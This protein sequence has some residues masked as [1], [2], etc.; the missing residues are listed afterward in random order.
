MRF[1]LLCS[2]KKSLDII[3]MGTPDFAVA[4]LDKIHKSGHKVRAVITSVDKPAGRGK[5][6]RQSA[7]KKYALEQDILILQP[8]NLKDEEFNAALKSLDADL[9]VVVAFR[10]LPKV[11]WDMPKM[12]TINL[13]GS[14]LPDY[15][16][17]APINWAVINGDNKTGVSTFF[18]NE[19]I[20]T[21]ELLL[22]R[23]INISKNDTAGSVHDAMMHIGAECLLETIDKIA[24]DDVNPIVQQWNSSFRKAPK[25]FKED[26]KIDWTLPSEV[27]YNKIRGL[28]PYPTA[29]TEMM[30]G[31]VKKSLKI[32]FAEIIDDTTISDG[33]IKI[34]E[35]KRMLIG[36]K[37][38][39][40][41][42]LDLQLEGKKRMKTSDF[43][44]GFRVDSALKA[45]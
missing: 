28:S 45:L 25:I 16:G 2:M 36:T 32:F 44:Q 5:K 33:D 24:L 42:I 7:V 21:G 15:R 31:E 41:N 6:L 40:L 22:Q 29:Y 26:C 8:K 17:A 10:M 39:C 35:E 38:G 1:H 37:D 11:V 27:I 30:N 13:H 3:F 12:G 20:D 14:L 23:E 34:T 9:F 19:K 43:L 18:I 4:S